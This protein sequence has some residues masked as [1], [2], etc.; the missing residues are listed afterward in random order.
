MEEPQDHR[1]EP[2]TKLCPECGETK[3][4]KKFGL[5]KGS[6]GKYYRKPKCNACYYYKGK[7]RKIR[8]RG[9][10]TPQTYMRWY[11]LQKKGVDCTPQEVDEMLERAGHSCE[12]CGGQ[13][14]LAID[15]CDDLKT[16]RGVLCMGCNVAIGHLK[17]DSALLIKALEYLSKDLDQEG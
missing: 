6:N 4:I 13:F 15:H 3:P 1:G 2:E 17:H 14:R 10:I 5:T 9:E 8:A 7:D 16:L 11:N 12:I